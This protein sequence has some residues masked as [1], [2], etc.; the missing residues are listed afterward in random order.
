MLLD[1]VIITR[2]KSKDKMT[3]QINTS[4]DKR[5]DRVT[6]DYEING[7]GLVGPVNQTVRTFNETFTVTGLSANDK[8][9]FVVTYKDTTA[10]VADSNAVDYYDKT[11]SDQS[12][13]PNGNFDS[14]RHMTRHGQHL[15]MVSRE[16]ESLGLRGAT[17]A[18]DVAT[19]PQLP[20]DAYRII[21]D[22]AVVSTTEYNLTNGART[23]SEDNIVVEELA[24]TARLL[25]DEIKPCRY[26]ADHTVVGVAN[27]FVNDRV[28]NSTDK[29][30]YTVTDISGGTSG[31]LVTW[32]DG[33]DPAI[34]END[35]WI[36]RIKSNTAP[37]PV[38]SEFRQWDG[39]DWTVV[40][41]AQSRFINA[42]QDVV[43]PKAQEN[44]LHYI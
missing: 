5:G 37:Y 29:K 32:D 23:V 39:T 2:F 17:N 40:S 26:V 6:I 36:V 25:N 33:L 4:A 28:I 22:S 13:L 20:G 11:D 3:I 24:T 21:G 9:H 15:Q 35:S 43:V 16:Q 7:G 18:S 10:T 27:L 44:K 42:H 30:V 31:N 12:L 19:F 34:V 41:I 14:M 8:L 1:P 38:T